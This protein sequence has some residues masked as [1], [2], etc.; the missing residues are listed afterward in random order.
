A[1]FGSLGATKPDLTLIYWSPYVPNVSEFL[2][3]LQSAS[4]PVPNFTNFSSVK[5]DALTDELRSSNR[6]IA[7]MAVEVQEV[8]DAEL[9]WLPL[10]MET[11][12]YLV[13]AR[14]EGFAMSPVS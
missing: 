12:L 8:L 3:A 9:P 7:E 1:L 13:S 5:L 14:V 2:T 11:P 10:Y 6:S 4:R